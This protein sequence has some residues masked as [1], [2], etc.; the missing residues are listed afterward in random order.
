[1]VDTKEKIRNAALKL[2]N[3]QGIDVITIRHIA[4]DL[5]I[6]HGN[7]QY[8]YKNTNDIILVL[9]NELNDGFSR[10][11][12]QRETIQHITL[13]HFR[14][15]ITALIELIWQYRFIFLHFVE[16]TRRVPEIKTIY[17]SWDKAREEQ[18]LLLFNT[19]IKEDI[20]RNDIPSHI[21]KNLIIQQYIMADFALSHN[22][23][24]MHLKGKKAVQYY[25]QVLFNQFYP[26][27][28]AKGRRQA[29]EHQSAN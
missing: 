19:L 27:L 4:K 7:L 5:D 21:W 22:E 26:Y 29:D 13:D 23:I 28:T 15:W 2:F 18:F 14:Q 1:M 9:F 10:V 3:D 17:N 25:S 11:F 12:M 8:H 6:S 20:F 16:V 24:K